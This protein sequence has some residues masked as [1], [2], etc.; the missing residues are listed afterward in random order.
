MANSKE[1]KKD[2]DMVKAIL[3]PVS[4]LPSMAPSSQQ[5]SQKS[6]ANSQ[7]EVNSQQS[8][9]QT[10][11]IIQASRSTQQGKPG[12]TSCPGPGQG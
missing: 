1:M 5:H 9:A 7:P 6:T 4:K 10:T 8:A 2:M 12:R 3:A 11:A